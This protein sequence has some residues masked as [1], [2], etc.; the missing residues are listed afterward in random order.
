MSKLVS[1]LS[2]VLLDVPCAWKIR[3]STTLGLVKLDDLGHY[4]TVIARKTAP[5]ICI[6]SF[7]LAS[8]A[9]A[10]K[11]KFV[12]NLKLLQNKTRWLRDRG[13]RL[14]I[15]Y[16]EFFYN[17]RNISKQ[18]INDCIQKLP[19]DLC[20]MIIY[21]HRRYGTCQNKWT[22]CDRFK[23]DWTELSQDWI[24]KQ[25]IS[26]SNNKITSWERATSEN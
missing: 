8:V 3:L 16:W 17:I 26:N 4:C 9:R 23:R 15:V 24:R 10:E 11:P 6:S 14:K 2:R 19:P 20:K 18:R 21:N 5:P 13:R 7:F 1:I 25:Y 22:R 12:I